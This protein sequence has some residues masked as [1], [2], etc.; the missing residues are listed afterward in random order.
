MTYR[1]TRSDARLPH[2][3]EELQ[4]RLIG[5]MMDGTPYHSILALARKPVVDGGLGTRTSYAALT[6]FYQQ[7]VHPLLKLKRRTARHIALEIADDLKKSPVD[8][9][10]STIEPLQ[11]LA[12]EMANT[13]GVDPRSVKAIYSL[14][15]KAR[16]Q[17]L[18]SRKIELLE[19]KAAQADQTAKV[20][21][22]PRLTPQ[23]RE[24]KIRR[25]IFGLG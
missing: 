20:L 23:E 8:W 21:Q 4:E 17:E 15:L 13:P 18:E 1:K 25:E 19:K 3:S 16:D 7:R 5:W 2:L 10:T 12:F 6:A 14:I 9:N 11:Q 24:Q 22:Q